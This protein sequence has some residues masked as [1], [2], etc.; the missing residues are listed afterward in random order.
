MKLDECKFEEFKVLF[1]VKQMSNLYLTELRNKTSLVRLVVQD[2]ET[3][4]VYGEH[5]QFKDG[6]RVIIMFD[7][8]PQKD[9]GAKFSNALFLRKVK[10]L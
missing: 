2:W 6:N 8:N 5:R 10:V 1:E 4:T 3:E 7:K 9:E